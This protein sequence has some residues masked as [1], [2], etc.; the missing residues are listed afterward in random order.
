[1]TRYLLVVVAIFGLSAGTA[2]AQRVEKAPMK[3]VPASDGAA[4]FNSY[5]AACHGLGATGDGPAAK[6]LSKV[7]ADLTR[8]SARAGGEFP[9]TRVKRYIEGL[10]EVAAHGTRDMPVWGPLFRSLEPDLV[11][12]RVQ[13][14]TDFL[15]SI[16]K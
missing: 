1:M 14:L 8:I 11:P 7:P 2:L 4:M 13:A 5:C 9:A 15:K 12:L 10:D 16:Q 6:A 3:R